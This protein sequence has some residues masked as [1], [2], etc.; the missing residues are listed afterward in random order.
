MDLTY[1][2]ISSVLKHI[3]RNQ[4]NKT[5]LDYRGGENVIYIG[6]ATPGT[7]IRTAKWQIKM[8]TYD[9]NDNVTSIRYARG[10]LDFSFK[11]T[12]RLVY[13]YS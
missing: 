3:F 10:T 1:Q 4:T 5:L 8:M 12:N 9:A 13:S 6:L 7:S 2:G 11:W